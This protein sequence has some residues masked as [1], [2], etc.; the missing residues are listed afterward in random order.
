MPFKSVYNAMSI[1]NMH[2]IIP[3]SSSI[4]VDNEKILERMNI[5]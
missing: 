3:E 2:P 5:I 1:H 4:N